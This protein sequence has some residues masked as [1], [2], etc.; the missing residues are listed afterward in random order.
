MVAPHNCNSNR[1]RLAFTVYKY[2]LHARTVMWEW[3]IIATVVLSA[4]ALC[5]VNSSYLESVVTYVVTRFA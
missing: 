5:V 4:S 1:P 3:D 2:K